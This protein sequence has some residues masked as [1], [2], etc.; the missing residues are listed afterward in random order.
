MRLILSSFLITL[1]TTCL[2]TMMAVF[3]GNESRTLGIAL[4]VQ[5]T[6][7][8]FVVAV[9]LYYT[10][11]ATTRV[12]LGDLLMLYRRFVAGWM[13]FVF[14]SINTLVIAG[15][16]SFFIVE[17]ASDERPPWLQ[18]VPLW[19]AAACTFAVLAIYMWGRVRHPETD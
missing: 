18:H 7:T 1:T 3:L 9:Y 10:W 16:L 5:A 12:G 19:C 4:L 6:L 2:V 11:L 8:P 14:W 13:W 15:E 17:W